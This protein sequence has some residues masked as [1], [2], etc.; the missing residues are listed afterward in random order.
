MSTQHAPDVTEVGAILHGLAE[1]GSFAAMERGVVAELRNALP[2]LGG[3]LAARKARQLV[4]SPEWRT[5]RA[6]DICARLGRPLIEVDEPTLQEAM[7]EATTAAV[8]ELTA[9]ALEEV[10]GR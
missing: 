4:A 10:G 6:L 3:A 7:N 1:A 2:A 5:Q 8:Y 9:E